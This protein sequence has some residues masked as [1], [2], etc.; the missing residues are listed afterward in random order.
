MY[1]LTSLASTSLM[2][3]GIEDRRKHMVILRRA[4]WQQNT[5]EPDGLGTILVSKE[6]FS[7]GD[8][9]LVEQI[10]ERMQ[11]DLVFSPRVSVDPAFATIASGRDLDAFMASF[12]LNIAAPTDDSPF[13]F[14]MLRLKDVF[15]RALREQGVMSFN[16]RAVY[17]LGVLLISVVGLTLLCIIVP[18]ILTTRKTALKGAWPLFVFFAAIGFGFML[19]EISQMQRLIVFLGHPT[20]GLSTVL[21]ALLLSSG[22]GSYL[23]EGIKNPGSARPTIALLILLGVLVAFGSLTPF[24]IRQFQGSTTTARILVAVGLLFPLGLFMGMPFPLGMKLASNRSASLTP[25]LWGINGATSVCAS[26]IAVVIALNSGISASFWT[27]FACY[28]AAL[29]TFVWMSRRSG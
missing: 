8:L 24:A 29:V 28:C 14:H 2:Q 9:D 3:L 19:V 7:D 1:R 18:L 26:V 13:F 22:L 11:F 20:Y 17:I 12:P 10:A 15:N 6:P 16:T 25:W 23:T 27:G 21:F 4:G 5:D